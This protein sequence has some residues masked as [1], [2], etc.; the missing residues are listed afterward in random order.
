LLTRRGS[1]AHV[2]RRL[3]QA[4][5]VANRCQACGLE[6][7][8]GRPLSIHIDHINGD[9]LDHR[10]DNL[11]MLCP[12]CHSQTDTYGAKNRRRRRLQEVPKVV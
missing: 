1:R 5:I 11:R 6:E 4:G 3:L 7:W 10:L 2:K 12:N 8:L 9:R